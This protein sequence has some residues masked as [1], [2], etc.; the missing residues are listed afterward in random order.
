MLQVFFPPASPPSLENCIAL[1]F[2][3]VIAVCTG[4]RGSLMRGVD[5][6]GGVEAGPE[7]KDCDKVRKFVDEARSAAVEADKG[8]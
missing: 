5:V 8:F 1:S 2:G 4:N 3:G 6:A 7:M